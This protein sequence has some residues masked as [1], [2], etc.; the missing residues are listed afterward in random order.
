MDS[1][2]KFLHIPYNQRWEY[3]KDT[4]IQLYTEGN[5]ADKVAFR[6]KSEYS[7]DAFAYKYQFK[8]WGIKKSTSSKVKAQAVKVQL[9]RKRD[10]ST[11]DLTIVEGGREKSLD[12]KKLK[13]FLQDDLRRRHEPT[14][15]G[16]R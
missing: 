10:A 9:K 5:S 11:S 13:R 2:P 6:M 16:G 3:L 15:A 8:K 4:I 12:K 14:L 7:F 1:D